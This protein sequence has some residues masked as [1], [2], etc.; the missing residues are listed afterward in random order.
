MMPVPVMIGLGLIGLGFLLA[1]YIVFAALNDRRKV[2]PLN[3]DDFE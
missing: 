1:I 3:E 2:K